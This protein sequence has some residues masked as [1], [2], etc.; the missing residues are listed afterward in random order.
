MYKKTKNKKQKSKTACGLFYTLK[1]SFYCIVYFT[2]ESRVDNFS[3]KTIFLHT[4]NNLRPG[5]IYVQT[6]L[7]SLCGVFVI[8]R[9]T[10]NYT[11]VS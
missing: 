6:I 2:S 7:N 11:D 9:G 10:K 3:S 4:Y 5:H 1:I 8:L